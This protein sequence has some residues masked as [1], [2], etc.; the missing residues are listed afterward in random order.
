MRRLVAVMAMLG[1]ALGLPTASRAVSPSSDLPVGG[2]PALYRAEPLLAQPRG[3]PFPDGFPRT[4]GFGRVTAGASYWSDFLY[5]DHGAK[6]VIVSGPVVDL[7]P[8]DGTLVYPPGKAAE[9]GADIFRAAVGQ[10]ASSSW[11]RVD[12]LTLADPAIPVALWAFD[13]DGNPSTGTAAWPAGAGV[14]SMGI[15]R[16]LLVSAKGAWLIDG[17]GHRVPVDH[18]TDLQSRSFV[19]RV[20]H[21]ILP[22]GGHWRIRLVSG[23]ATAAGD[24]F[25]PV[26]VS[27]G[28][29]PGQPSVF[30]VAFRSDAQEPVVGGN[31]WREKGQ[32]AS[33]ATGDVTPFARD[34][35]WAALSRRVSEPEPRPAGYT[36]R[37]YV[38]SVELGQG[39]VRNPPQYSSDLRPN[40]L[41]RV[42]PYG[43]FV[44]SGVAPSQAVPLTLLLHSLNT[45]HNQYAAWNPLFL[46]S[47]CQGR[48]SICLMPMARGPDSWFFDEGELDLWETWNR[49]ARAFA[50]DPSRSIVA[51]YSMGGYGTYRLA[52]EHP[53]LFAQA[54]AIAGPP[55]CAL[56]LVSPVEVPADP[57]ITKCE[58]EADT[59]PLV[60]N[61]EHLPFYI[62]QGAVDE[63]VW[64]P[65]AVQ[66]ARRFD[67]LGYRYRLEL[68]GR[69]GHVDWAETGHFQ[70]AVAWLRDLRREAP[71]ARIS[72]TFYPSHQRPDLGVGPTGAWWLTELAARSHAVGFVATATAFSHALP[73]RTPTLLRGN[74]AVNNDDGPAAVQVLSW[75]AST[76]SPAARWID[77]TFTG[78]AHAAVNVAQAGLR[79]TP[80]T[81]KVVSDRPTQLH[82]TGLMVGQ[83]VLA[84]DGSAIADARGQATVST[85]GSQLIHLLPRSAHAS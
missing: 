38:S 14:A 36:N 28:A 41:N 85:S 51:G 23:V 7:S 33:L 67:T 73:D 69:Q 75:G 79:D 4:S 22:V 2:P 46:Q 56:R 42:Q 25:A 47:L 18:R 10:D 60:G 27:M 63:L 55:N 12:W 50:L 83:T 44:P 8:P 43:I 32:A 11:W 68:Y 74:D 78:V 5:D 70:G 24:G 59:S 35:D 9:N 45:Q 49:V 54:V 17:A 40:Y 30:N 77:L 53:D 72:Y 80:A 31:W 15:E 3:W 58:H 34:I 21:G 29:L 81:I 82:L 71:P 39:I 76:P 52:F 1:L 66:Q 65:S 48:R 62:G 37:W 57:G 20:P 26:D 13:T 61:A 64:S 84:P 6:G 19:V 16:W